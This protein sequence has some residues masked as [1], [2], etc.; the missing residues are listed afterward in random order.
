MD[1]DSIPSL[2]IHG[3]DP[4]LALL[5]HFYHNCTGEGRGGGVKLKVVDFD[6]IGT[7]EN[8]LNRVFQD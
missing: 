7:Y 3:Y 1:P 8:V 2:E 4:T 5:Q 6:I